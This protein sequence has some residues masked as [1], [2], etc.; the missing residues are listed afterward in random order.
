[1]ALA[2]IQQSMEQLQTDRLRVLL[3]KIALSILLLLGF[4]WV[5]VSLFINEILILRRFQGPY[6]G[7]S[8]RMGLLILSSLCLTNLAPTFKEYFFGYLALQ[9]ILSY[10]IAGYVKIINLEW[11]NGKALQD[12]F[13]FSAYPATEAWRALADRPRLLYLMSW[14]V[15]LFELVFPFTLVSH[16]LLIAGIVTAFCFHLANACLFGLNRFVWVWLAAYPSLIWFQDQF[17]NSN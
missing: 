13:Q 16:Q 14:L 2:F 15:M 7:G 12:L 5:C 10:F 9:V 3:V 8:D 4:S 17:I 6:N 1:M 11:R